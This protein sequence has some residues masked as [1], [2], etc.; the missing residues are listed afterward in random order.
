MNEEKAHVP[1]AF[2]SNGKF[3][4]NEVHWSTSFIGD[5][6]YLQMCE[7]QKTVEV[8]AE[9]NSY[10]QLNR[11]YYQAD[12]YAARSSIGNFEGKNAK[13]RPIFYLHLEDFSPRLKAE[14]AAL[15]VESITRIVTEA[16]FRIFRA[17][18]KMAFYQ[19]I[20]NEP[21]RWKFI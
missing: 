5:Q 12:V 4:T 21:L 3:N 15:H 20:E 1:Q 10:A 11:Y 14:L 6:L 17:R 7:C 9:Q 8:K 18:R 2:L 19:Y 16:S 13:Y